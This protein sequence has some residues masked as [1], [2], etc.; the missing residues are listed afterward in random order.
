[1]K[2]IISALTV[3][4]LA[5]SLCGCG[6]KAKDEAQPVGMPNPLTEVTAQELLEKTG[7]HFNTPDG[8]EDIHYFTL[9]AETL[10]AQMTFKVDGK[11]VTVRAI[12]DGIPENRVVRDI[13]GMYY[14]WKTVENGPV[15][16][17]D[18]T[19]KLNEGEQ[20]WVGWYDYVP[21]ITYNVSMDSGASVA[22]LTRLAEICCPPVQGDVG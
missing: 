22:E 1:M 19:F 5:L 15:F 11:K 7:F 9:E 4:T 3:L 18:A 16:Y 10:T 14:E 2:K 20:G 12:P 8:A 21:G 13:S 17:N 6:A